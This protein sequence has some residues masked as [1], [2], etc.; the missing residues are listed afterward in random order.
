M[1]ACD[2]LHHS[3]MHWSAGSS[4]VD[5]SQESGLDGGASGH[6]GHALGRLLR[7]PWAS[8]ASVRVILLARS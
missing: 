5:K 2:A 3:L 8:D 6:D 1:H 7:R 4:V